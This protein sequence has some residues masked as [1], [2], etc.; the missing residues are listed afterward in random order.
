[1]PVRFGGEEFMV[2]LPQTKAD[3]LAEIGDRLR[4]AVCAT[5]VTAAD[6]KHSIPVTVSVGLTV[7]R[8]DEDHAEAL[9]A[10]ADRALYRAKDAGRNRVEIDYG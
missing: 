9:L 7:F 3:T 10:R 6:G 4:L 8:P 1:M 5:P 2:I